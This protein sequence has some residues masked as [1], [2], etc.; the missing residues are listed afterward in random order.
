[1]KNFLISPPFGSYIAHSKCT[2]V[3]GTYTLHKRG[4]WTTK[5]CRAIKTIR[6]VKNGW[7]NNIGLQNPG[8]KSV[9]SFDQEKIYSIAA[10]QSEEWDGLIDYIPENTTVELNLSCPN[11]DRKTDID[12]YQVVTFI[13]KFP[14]VI[15][16]LSPTNEVYNQVDRL[17]KL[18]ARYLHIANTLPTNR[19][20]E[21]GGRLKEFSLKTIKNIRGK[22]PD[23]EIIGGGGIYSYKDIELYKDAGADYF[24][25]ATIWFTP[26]R[27]VWLLKNSNPADL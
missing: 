4:G 24:S 7:V 5:L 19:G 17:V 9:K 8:I 13:N 21:S 18:G 27:A 11:L 23:I 3:Y 6:P 22:Y 26:W 25:L 15:F 16:K 10:I 14:T 12:D 2:S 20:G 1:M